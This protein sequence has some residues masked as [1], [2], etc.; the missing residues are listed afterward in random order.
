[1]QRDEDRERQKRLRHRH[2]G[3]NEE[4]P[5][6]EVVLLEKQGSR[7]VMLHVGDMQDLRGETAELL[8]QRLSE[9]VAPLHP[10]HFC[11][12][13]PSTFMFDFYLSTPAR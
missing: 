2:G 8:L 12:F 5:D 7:R 10:I 9:P 4:G 6:R 11:T 3:T 13:Q 1:M